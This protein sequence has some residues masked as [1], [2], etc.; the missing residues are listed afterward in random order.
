MFDKIEVRNKYIHLSPNK[1]DKSLPLLVMSHGSGGISDIDLDFA[2][3]ACANGYQ[4]AVIDHYTPRNIEYQL[5]DGSQEFTP[6]FNDRSQDISDILCDYVTDKRLVFGISAGGTAAI[7]CSNLFS[8]TFCVYPALIAITSQMLKAKNITIVTGRNDNWTP[9]DQARHFAQHVECDLHII[10]GYHGFLNPRQCRD[11][12][13]IM[14]LRNQ[15]LDVP[16]D[17]SWMHLD[18]ER[19]IR[20]EY[21]IRSR[22]YTQNLFTQWL[23]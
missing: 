11:I 12:P 18:F 7:S 15:T 8:K 9:A 20:L 16:W 6:S 1:L 14:S 10:D 4:C 5:W 21:N 2:K 13:Q 17:E 3:I 19:G 23:S 22:L